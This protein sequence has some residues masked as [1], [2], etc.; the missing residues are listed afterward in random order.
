MTKEKSSGL[1]GALRKKVFDFLDSEANVMAEFE[2]GKIP[3][4]CLFSDPR[5]RDSKKRKI[6]CA[7]KALAKAAHPRES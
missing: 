2:R 4:A 6:R 7:Q 3:E 5:F 1:A